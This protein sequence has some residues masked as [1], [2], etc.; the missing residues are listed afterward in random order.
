MPDKHLKAVDDKDPKAARAEIAEA[1]RRADA[2]DCEQC[3]AVIQGALA[4]F[5]CDLAPVAT[6]STNGVNLA[7]NVVKRR[8]AG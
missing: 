7:V 2:K 8:A 6:L 4:D 3:M 5:G 1:L